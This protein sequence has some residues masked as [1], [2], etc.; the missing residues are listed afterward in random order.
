MKDY[1]EEI[2]ILKQK[3]AAANTLL[4]QL[5]T[6]RT[7]Y[8]KQLAARKAYFSSREIL[9]LIEEKGG[10][11]S[12]MATI[13]RWAD[14]GH[15]GGCI[16]ER[17]CFP[18]LVSKQGNKRFLYPRTTV[19]TFLHEK[20]YLRP[21]YEVLD[22]VQLKTAKGSHAWGLITAVERHDQHFTYQVQME[23][24]GEVLLAVPEEELL[25]P[26]SK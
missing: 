26:S 21:S 7:N 13:K 20:G 11:A 18:L 23:K 17:E 3:I 10:R 2:M 22:R 9:D 4:D 5:E 1:D 15:L 14:Q 19:L 8:L 12:S 25:L 24:T 16:D 6:E